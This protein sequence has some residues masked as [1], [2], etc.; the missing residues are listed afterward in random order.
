MPMKVKLLREVDDLGGKGSTHELD[1]DQANALVSAG[2]A[3]QVNP[4]EVT[5]HHTSA[6]PWSPEK[7]APETE[8]LQRLASQAQEEGQDVQDPGP[9]GGPV[10]PEAASKTPSQRAATGAGEDETGRRQ[11]QKR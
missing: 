4:F 7:F 10:D 8:R 11:Q 5:E 6:P 9:Q 2:A 1:D 3:Q